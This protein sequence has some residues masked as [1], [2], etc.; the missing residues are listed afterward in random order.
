MFKCLRVISKVDN[1]EKHKIL[2]LGCG[3]SEQKILRKFCNSTSCRFI[4]GLNINLRD[5]FSLIVA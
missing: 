2:K 4:V 3:Y 5:S 1:D